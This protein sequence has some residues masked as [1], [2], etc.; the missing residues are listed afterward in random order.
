MRVSAIT[1]FGYPG[2]RHQR[3]LLEIPAGSWA[4]SVYRQTE[5]SENSGAWRSRTTR[6][7]FVGQPPN[8]VILK[9]AY[10]PPRADEV[11]DVVDDPMAPIPSGLTTERVIYWSPKPFIVIDE[12]E[13]PLDG[14]WAHPATLVTDHGITTQ[15]PKL[16]LPPSAPSLVCS[17]NGKPT[18]WVRLTELAAACSCSD[19]RELVRRYQEYF[20]GYDPGVY[21]VRAADADLLARLEDPRHGPTWTIPEWDAFFTSDPSDAWIRQRFAI[22]VMYFHMLS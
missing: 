22:V 9:R 7:S 10:T 1:S 6:Q 19:A 2:E 13:S 18:K 14:K 4:V 3:E 12:W 21:I 11:M 15:L 20:E 17:R 5:D 8:T 16:P